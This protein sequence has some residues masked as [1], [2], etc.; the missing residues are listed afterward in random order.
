VL[1]GPAALMVIAALFISVIALGVTVTPDIRSTELALEL[2]NAAAMLLLN[3][4]V[5]VV[6]LFH[7]ISTPNGELKAVPPNCK[8]MVTESMIIAFP[9]PGAAISDSAVPAVLPIAASCVG[10]TFT[11]ANCRPV[12]STATPLT[13]GVPVNAGELSGAPPP[14]E[15]GVLLT[16]KINCL[17]LKLFVLSGSQLLTYDGRSR[18]AADRDTRNIAHRNRELGVR[19]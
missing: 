14:P 1:V 12:A 9:A 11:M 13:V 10:V 16:G 3:A 18:P 8:F 7:S 17:L 2:T 5:S 15:P 4:C 19:H 6:P